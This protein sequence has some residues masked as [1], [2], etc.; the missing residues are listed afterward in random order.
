MKGSIKTR[1]SLATRRK[2][3]WPYQVSET[4]ATARSAELVFSAVVTE[5]RLGQ[6]ACVVLQQAPGAVPGADDGP[7]AVGQRAQHAEQLV[8]HAEQP[9]HAEPDGGAVA[10]HHGQG[11]RA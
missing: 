8:R 1:L 3:A 10:D 5:Y 4:E 11:V 7:G 6:G 2:P 9:G